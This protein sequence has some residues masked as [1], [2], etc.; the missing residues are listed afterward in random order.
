[1][2]TNSNIEW[3]DH[4]WNPWQGCTRVSPGCKHCYMYREKQ[5]YGQ[6]P[7]HVVCSAHDTFNA[8]LKRDRRG[9]YKWPS[10]SKVFVCSWSDFFHPAADQWRP[11]AYNIMRQRPDLIYQIVTKRPEMIADRLPAD[12]GTGWPNTWLITSIESN[13]YIPRW[14]ALQKIPAHIRGVSYEPALEW[15]DLPSI[16]SIPSM[17]SIEWCDCLD[18]HD[19]CKNCQA[20]LDAVRESG[21]HWLIAGT[22]SGPYAR[23]Y[24]LSWFRTTADICNRAGIA[25]YMKQLTKDGRKIAYDKWPHD[26]QVRQ[27][28]TGNANLPIGSFPTQSTGAT[29]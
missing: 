21:L 6:D 20:L 11:L 28:P 25:F 15:L 4:T 14:F 8:P 19:T 5:R 3:T 29:K 22:E 23:P 10:G 18:Q 24:D 12:W 2:T 9:Q 7:Q 16:L 13:K 26:L 17:E 1:M 27:F